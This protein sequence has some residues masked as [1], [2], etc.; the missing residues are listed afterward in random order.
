MPLT[1]QFWGDR[2]GCLED[3]FGHRWWLAERVKDLSD[4]ELREAAASFFASQDRDVVVR[5]FGHD[6]SS[7]HGLGN[8]STSRAMGLRRAQ[9]ARSIRAAKSMPGRPV[10]GMNAP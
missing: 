4:G 8:A 5:A 7:D 10:R 6:S 9:V 1:D 2:C 3:P